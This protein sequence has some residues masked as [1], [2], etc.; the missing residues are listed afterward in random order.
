MFSFLDVLHNL[1]IQKGLGNIA[2]L[3][4][5]TLETQIVNRKP[6]GMI[7]SVVRK[8]VV[9]NLYMMTCYGAR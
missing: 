9:M 1:K 6:D 8:E 3:A 5:A 4:T 2:L 7:S